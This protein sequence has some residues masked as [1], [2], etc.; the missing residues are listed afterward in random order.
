MHG[1]RAFGCGIFRDLTPKLRAEE[2]MERYRTIVSSTPDAIALLDENHR[3][4]IVNAAYERFSG[5]KREDILGRSPARYLREDVFQRD[6]KPRIDRAF[7]GEKVNC[8][9]WFEYPKLG[10]RFMDITYFPLRN[11]TGHIVGVV[12]NTRDITE[13]KHSEQRIALLSQQ[14]INSQESE[15][16]MISRELHDSIAQDLS[17]VKMAC[18]QLVTGPFALPAAAEQKVSG[19]FDMLDRPLRAV[20]DLSYDLRPPGLDEMGLVQALSMHCDDFSE[21]T[22]I[23]VDFGSTGVT[24][25]RL[26]DQT[27]INLYRLVQ[28]ALNNV[29]KHAEA[30]HVRVKLVGGFPQIILRI[31]DNGRG[32]DVEDRLRKMDAG[33]RMGLRSMEERVNLLGGEWNLHSK[34]GKGTKIHIKVPCAEGKNG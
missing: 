31:E 19:I 24:R 23:S 13:L 15:R 20:R 6:V 16:Q 29:R 10:K 3:Y 32:F 26:D 25:L 1:N 33:K 28:E 14:L 2:E 27:S 22:G 12:T 30:G 18:K 9:Q 7:R 8:R 11:T 17:A 4:A 5:F 34:P 21:K